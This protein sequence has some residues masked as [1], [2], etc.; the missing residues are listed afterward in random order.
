M[1][2]TKEVDDDVEGTPPETPT[3]GDP[4]DDSKSRRSVPREIKADA[5]DDRPSQVD[6][7]TMFK[8]WE[9]L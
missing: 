8:R 4:T 7:G 3:P 5:K 1:K 9:W 2:P 6:I